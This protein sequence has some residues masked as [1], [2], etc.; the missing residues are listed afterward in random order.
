MPFGS[1]PRGIEAEGRLRR[2]VLGLDEALPLHLCIEGALRDAQDARGV[3]CALRAETA[4]QVPLR[5]IDRP[6]TLP[7]R[8]TELSVIIIRQTSATATPPCLNDQLRRHSKNLRRAIH[9]PK[10]RRGPGRQRTPMVEHD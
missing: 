5:L 9:Q 2:G 8:T 7:A 4:A 1:V 3:S 6:L 10:T